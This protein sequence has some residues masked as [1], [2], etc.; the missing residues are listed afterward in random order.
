MA[1]VFVGGFEGEI[2]EPEEPGG[3]ITGRVH[4]GD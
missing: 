3:G 1:C 2:G 4:L